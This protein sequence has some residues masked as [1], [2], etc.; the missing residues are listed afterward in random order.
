M[1]FSSYA[2]RKLIKDDEKP[3]LNIVGRLSFRSNYLGKYSLEQL[4][5]TYQLGCRESTQNPPKSSKQ[6]LSLQPTVTIRQWNWMVDSC[7]MVTKCS[8]CF[9]K[10][11]LNFEND[12]CWPDQ[13]RQRNFGVYWKKNHS[14]FCW[15]KDT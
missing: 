9:Y 5:S 3:P 12:D 6:F 7:T 11:D 1:Q 10:F 14:N 15:E 2:R 8:F 13:K 4:F